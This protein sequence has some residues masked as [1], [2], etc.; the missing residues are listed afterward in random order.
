MNEPAPDFPAV[1]SAALRLSIEEQECLVTAL[2]RALGPDDHQSL[3]LLDPLEL[4]QRDAALR[5]D[6]VAGLGPSEFEAAM[7]RHLARVIS[8]FSAP[9]LAEVE[10][11]PPFVPP[12]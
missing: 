11:R 1:L 6:Q 8:Y 7:R 10:S 3:S 9:D 2:L 4:E 12:R 5:D